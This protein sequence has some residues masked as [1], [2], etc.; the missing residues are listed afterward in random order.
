MIFARV[1]I[2]IFF[3]GCLMIFSSVGLS[4][5]IF[6]YPRAPCHVVEATK[7]RTWL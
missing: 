6:Y 5:N 7:I 2:V 3:Y 4:Y 1:V